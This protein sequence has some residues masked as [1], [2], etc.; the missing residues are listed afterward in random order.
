MSH[1]DRVWA[2][3]RGGDA[4]CWQRRVAGREVV[5]EH[6]VVGDAQVAQPHDGVVVIV[7]ALA[8]LGEPLLEGGEAAWNIGGECRFKQGWTLW[9]GW[10]I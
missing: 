10:L 2:W 1:L 3:Y 9:V 6:V 7:E 4:A 5:G 8:V